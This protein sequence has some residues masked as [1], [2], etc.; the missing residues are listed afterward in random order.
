MHFI[1][2]ITLTLNPMQVDVNPTL[3]MPMHTAETGVI[4]T[5]WVPH[6]IT[7]DPRYPQVIEH[8][9]IH[10]KQ[11]TALGPALPVAYMLSGGRAFE[12]YRDMMWNPPE[13]MI[14]NCPLLRV[15]DG[16]EF[17]PC[18]RLGATGNG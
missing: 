17:M 2:T 18:Y 15:G 13:E 12:D 8:E 9:L 7:Y 14:N 11:Y 5:T 6:V 1:I 10:A 4:G 16:V 3:I